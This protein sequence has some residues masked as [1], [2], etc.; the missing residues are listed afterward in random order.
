MFNIAYVKMHEHLAWKR[1]ASLNL[2]DSGF[3]GF[4]V[5]F[6]NTKDVLS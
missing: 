3:Y 2:F 6:G 5:L 1:Q 4:I